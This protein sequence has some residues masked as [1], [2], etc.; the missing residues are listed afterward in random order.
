MKRSI[1]FLLVVALTV[2]LSA[3]AVTADEHETIPPHP[4]MLV[5]GVEY[6]EVTEE[7]I[8]YQRCIDLAGNN[9]LPLRS[10]HEHVHFGQAGV[11]L[12]AAGHAVVP[13]GPAFGLPWTN[14]EELI[15]AFF[16]NGS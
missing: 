12:D 13:G 4:H 16:P 3:T 14:C 15:E 8:G 6:D 7:P 2:L 1:P 10:Q 9:T 11:A 5:L